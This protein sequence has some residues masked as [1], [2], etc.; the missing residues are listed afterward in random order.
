MILDRRAIGSPYNAKNI[1]TRID[2]IKNPP[3][4]VYKNLIL[5]WNNL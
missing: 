1:P 4:R 2:E 3:K 5:N